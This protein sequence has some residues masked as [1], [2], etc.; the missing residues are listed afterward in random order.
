MFP[1]LR[2]AKDYIT[3]SSVGNEFLAITVSVKL[4]GTLRKT[5]T[6]L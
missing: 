6:L 4:C 2:P 5:L 1:C 3:I